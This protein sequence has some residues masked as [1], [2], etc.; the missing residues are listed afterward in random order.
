MFIPRDPV[1]ENMFCQYVET[2]TSTGCG[3]W[4]AYAGAVVFINGPAGND[5][6]NYVSRSTLVQTINTEDGGDY[7]AFGFLEQAIKV[8]YHDVHPA[9]YILDKDFG[10]SHVV[11]K[12]RFAAGTRTVD[13][14]KATPVAVAHLG[15]WE[16]THY[17]A[18]DTQIDPGAKMY[19]KSAADGK[20]QVDTSGAVANATQVAICM[21]GVS[22]ARATAHDAGTTLW[23]IR[24]KL[25]I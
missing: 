6:A 5:P 22:T 15:I 21:T 11:A 13:G 4:V 18:N 14:T 25:L 7:P 17:F 9:G 19:V 2:D 16:T 1:N 8:G 24:L 20:I 12:P 23:S 10:M 3:A